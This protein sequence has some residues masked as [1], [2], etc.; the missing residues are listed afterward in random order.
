M[1]LKWYTNSIQNRIG[2]LLWREEIEKMQSR[3]CIENKS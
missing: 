2:V 3:R 1:R